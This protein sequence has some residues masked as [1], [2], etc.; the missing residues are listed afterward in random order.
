MAL[1]LSHF[2]GFDSVIYSHEEII[3]SVISYRL[4]SS[5]S[6]C[7]RKP[8]PQWL[9]ECVRFTLGRPM[10]PL[11]YRSLPP[12]PLSLWFLFH[13]PS[14]LK[15]LPGILVWRT[16]G[17][18]KGSGVAPDSQCLHLY[19]AGSQGSN[20]FSY[21]SPACC[22]PSFQSLTEEHSSSSFKSSHQG[23]T[24]ETQLPKCGQQW[25]TSTGVGRALPG[26]Q[27]RWSRGGARLCPQG[28][29]TTQE[30]DREGEIRSGDKE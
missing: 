22:S 23:H 9:A 19:T 20:N 7:H 15:L 10:L 1:I 28:G 2:K 18:P 21:S 17:T 27:S 14:F 3:D 16:A 26:N 4:L 13:S 24:Q 30:S 25:E 8:R 11:L 6:L 12:R 5:F 29:R